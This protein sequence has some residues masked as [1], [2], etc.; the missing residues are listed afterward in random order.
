M[1]VF[2]SRDVPS[3]VLVNHAKKSDWELI[4]FSCIQKTVV[5]VEN[6]PSADWIF[7]YSP[8][9]VKLFAKNF[10]RSTQRFAALGEGTAR[11]MRECEMTPDF[12]GTSANPSEAVAEFSDVIA[13]EELVVQARGERSFERLREVL[14]T[15]QII[16]WP[17]YRSEPKSNI[18]E[19]AAD[20]YIF[21]SP[22]NAE[23]Y[24][25]KHDL[26]E[27]SAVVVFGEST[28]TAVQKKANIRILV[29]KPPG[30]ESAI[31]RIVVDLEK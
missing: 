6:P 26:P 20:Y 17:F 16:D 9:A 29:T 8:G 28:K 15:E 18:P 22:S 11:A 31:Q 19:I 25:A 21:T 4:C 12:V 1:K 7:F 10:N 3:E 13:T 23:A 14:S 2:L 30:E 24:L 27:K 5:T